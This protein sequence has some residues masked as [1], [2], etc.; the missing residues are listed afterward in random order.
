MPS[1]S[2]VE[3]TVVG[4]PTN[5]LSIVTHLVCDTLPSHSLTHLSTEST[6]LPEII[7]F[8][9]SHTPHT[10][11]AIID[12]SDWDTVTKIGSK[13]RGGAS[14]RE[15]TIKSQSALNA[16][17]R[18]GAVVATDKKFATGNQVG[19]SLALSDD[20]ANIFCRLKRV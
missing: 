15:T 1:H 19:T 18:T 8:S 6:H 17:Q 3:S 9:P 10:S 2:D 16:A 11:S 14:Q 7:I 4:G 5:I 13:A 20:S 12:M